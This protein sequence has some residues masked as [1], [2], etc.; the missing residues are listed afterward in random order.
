MPDTGSKPVARLYYAFW[1]AV[2]VIVVVAVVVK[3]RL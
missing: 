3:G 1:I 2:L